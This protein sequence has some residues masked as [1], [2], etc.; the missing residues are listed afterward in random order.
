M[1]DYINYKHAVDAIN[2]AV[3]NKESEIRDI[4]KEIVHL[5]KTRRMMDDE[6]SKRTEERPSFIG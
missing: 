3:E 1:S 5:K 2:F 4:E 6:F